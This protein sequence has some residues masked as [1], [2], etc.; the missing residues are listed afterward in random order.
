MS[1]LWNTS[2]LRQHWYPPSEGSNASIIRSMRSFVDERTAP[3]RDIPSQDITDMKA[4]FGSMKLD[5][6]QSE[7]SSASGQSSTDF[8]AHNSAADSE[9]NDRIFSASPSYWEH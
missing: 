2:D 6:G 1:E 8:F 3:A 4:I 5:E 9:F 7:S